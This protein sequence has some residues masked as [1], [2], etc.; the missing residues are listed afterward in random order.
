MKKKKYKEDT[1]S[2]FPSLD[3][4]KFDSLRVVPNNNFPRKNRIAVNISVNAVEVESTE[5]SLAYCYKIIEELTSK[6][7]AGEKSVM[8]N[9]SVRVGI[10]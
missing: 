2:V 10:R 9:K 4:S 1:S 7:I 3:L 8:E 6:L 5:E